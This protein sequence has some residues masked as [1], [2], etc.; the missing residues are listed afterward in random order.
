MRLVLSPAALIELVNEEAEESEL[1]LVNVE[2]SFYR[3]A[4]APRVPLSRVA[5]LL[6]VVEGP[7]ERE[8]QRVVPEALM[9]EFHRIVEERE[10]HMELGAEA[11]FQ[12]EYGVCN[13]II[14]CALEVEQVSL[15]SGPQV[16]VDFE[17]DT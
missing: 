9:I 11:S 3:G 4:E 8:V 16:A 2:C 7:Q 5:V 12:V 15:V 17:P 14:R 1:A 13:Q 6:G 10:V